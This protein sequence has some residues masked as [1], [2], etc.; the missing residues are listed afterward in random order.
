MN[1][2]PRL[3]W[4]VTASLGFLMAAI[5]GGVFALAKQTAAPVPSLPTPSVTVSPSPSNSGA[6][7]TGKAVGEKTR[8]L[9]R[10]TREFG[11]GFRDGADTKPSEEKLRR[12]LERYKKKLQRRIDELKAEKNR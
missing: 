4:V 11:D 5:L 2:S 8:E 9:G 3:F 6:Y 7:D 12:D 10:K 1:I